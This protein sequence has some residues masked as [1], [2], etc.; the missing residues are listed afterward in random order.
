MTREQID[1]YAEVSILILIGAQTV[2]PGT[3]AK[4]SAAALA[5]FAALVERR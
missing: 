5:A 2:D 4:T 1:A 3:A